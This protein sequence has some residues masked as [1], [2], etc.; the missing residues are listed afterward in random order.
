MC[1]RCYV[2][3]IGIIVII[4]CVG[5]KYINI[6]KMDVTSDGDEA[7]IKCDLGTSADFMIMMINKQVSTDRLFKICS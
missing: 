5:Y 6:M 4:Y 1:L 2:W 3:N 7:Y